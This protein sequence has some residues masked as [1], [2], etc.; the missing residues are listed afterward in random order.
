MT[1]DFLKLFVI[2]LAILVVVILIRWI[3][4]AVCALGD[5]FP[6]DAH[7]HAYNI[8]AWAMIGLAGWG[9]IRVLRQR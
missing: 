8:A 9:I 2:G 4:A 7:S 6:S 3:F 1:I 5:V